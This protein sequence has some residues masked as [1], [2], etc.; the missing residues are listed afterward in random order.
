MPVRV[1]EY[2]ALLAI[3]CAVGVRKVEATRLALKTFRP[4]VGQVDGLTDH[5]EASSR[6][7]F[8]GR[9]DLSVLTGRPLVRCERQGGPSHASALGVHR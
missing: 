7:P 4:E 3:N 5:A 1:V 2:S 9:W 6:H 8:R